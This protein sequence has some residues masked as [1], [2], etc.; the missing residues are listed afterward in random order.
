MTK[1]KRTPGQRRLERAERVLAPVGAEPGLQPGDDDARVACEPAAGSDARASEGRSRLSFS[2]LP[3]ETIHHMRLRPSRRSAVFRHHQMRGMRRV[4]RAAIKAD[5]HA[6]RMWRDAMIWRKDP[7][8]G[9]AFSGA[10][11][12]IAM[13]AIFEGAELL[14]TDR[15]AGMHAAGGEADLRAEAEFAAIGETGSR[16]YGSRWRSQPRR[17]SAAPRLILGQD[18][19]GV[20]EP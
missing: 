15:P 11:L 1:T 17:G 16:R 5:H 8:R 13:D 7:H 20:C 3:G 10:G 19:I 18:R 14:D 6:A 9:N 4:E 2:G 12:A